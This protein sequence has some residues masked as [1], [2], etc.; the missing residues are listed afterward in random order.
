MLIV[1]KSGVKEKV[2]WEGK[3]KLTTSVFEE[4]FYEMKHH[5]KEYEVKIGHLEK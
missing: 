5:T 2:E 3:S 1:K 4:Q